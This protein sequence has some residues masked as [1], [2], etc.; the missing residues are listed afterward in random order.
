MVWRF[1]WM[2]FGVWM[3][4][5]G[6]NSSALASGAECRDV[7]L[8]HPKQLYAITLGA[9]LYD[10]WYNELEV[11]PPKENHPTYPKI[12][13]DAFKPAQNWRCSSC[14]GWDGLGKDGHG[15]VQTDMVGIYGHKEDSLA[16]IVKQLKGGIHGYEGRMPDEAFTAL[17]QFIK[18]GP[19]PGDVIEDLHTLGDKRR[20]E[21]FYLTLCSQCHGENGVARGMPVLGKVVQQDPWRVLHKT[22][23]GHPGS[24][25]VA[26]RA[27]GRGVTMDLLSHMQELPTSK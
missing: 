18:A 5:A 8:E 13:P 17:A 25:M 15:Q 24:G 6:L 20:G 10:N 12:L 21:G 9:R 27:L 14:H 11:S 16:Q 19:L 23:Y 1:G 2:A 4:V 26:L 7:L 3:M 22:L